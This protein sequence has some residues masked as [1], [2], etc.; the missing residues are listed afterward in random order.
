MPIDISLCFHFRQRLRFPAR[1]GGHLVPV[2]GAAL[3]RHRRQRDERQ[4]QL[5]GARPRRRR[6]VHPE[7]VS[8]AKVPSLF[9]PVTSRESSLCSLCSLIIQNKK[10][11]F[12]L[13]ASYSSSLVLWCSVSLSVCLSSELPV[14]SKSLPF[15]ILLLHRRLLPYLRAAPRKCR[16]Q[17]QSE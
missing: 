8:S 3:H 14:S 1:V 16:D 5:R 11:H 13:V 6:E 2:D 15:P 12:L 10:W 9:S 17:S 7:I 4:G